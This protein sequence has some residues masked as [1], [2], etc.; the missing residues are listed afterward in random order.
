MRECQERLI[1]GD[2]VDSD[3]AITAE[4]EQKL[5][6][7]HPVGGE[8][9]ARPTVSW[10]EAYDLYRQN[11][12]TRV[13]PMSL[14][15][16]LS[17]IQM[18]AKI[19]AG[20][21]EDAGRSTEFSVQEV[22]TLCQLEYLQDRLLAGDE[23]RY[24]SRSPNSVNSMMGA[25]MAFVNFCHRR[26]WIAGVPYV[27]KLDADDAMRGR[28]ISAGE[29]QQLLDAVPE[30]VGQDVALSWQFTL[31]LIWESGFRIA[32][33]MDFC[34]HDPRHIRPIWPD[35]PGIHPTIG[36]PATQKNGRT[37]EIPMLPGLRQL[38][39]AVPIRERDG[40]IANPHPI[41]HVVHKDASW[42]RPCKVDL[43]M[44]TKDYTNRAIGRA[45]GVTDT[46]VRA[47]LAQ[48]GIQSFVGVPSSF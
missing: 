9:V 10:D 31:R 36:I 33:V 19:L 32:D 45:C 39:E 26:N 24:D 29:F 42:I 8:G 15:H 46:T 35:R 13:R 12:S 23:G 25:V 17:R 3:G 28:P 16:T 41:Q 11:R 22:M 1:N 30:V 27:Q 43:R 6:R 5:P 21:R 2:Y 18:A 14:T 38:L 7:R 4:H 20:Q 37:Q 40:W 48:E 47:W 34:W 44:L